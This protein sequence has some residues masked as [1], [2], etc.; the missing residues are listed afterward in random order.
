MIKPDVVIWLGPQPGTR[1]YRLSQD[2]GWKKLLGM[3]PE[4]YGDIV[5]GDPYGRSVG[6]YT[7]ER[8]YA[9]Q[10]PEWEDYHDDFC[11]ELARF[12]L[13]HP[14][15]DVA[16]YVGGLHNLLF[17][18]KLRDKGMLRDTLRRC[19]DGFGFGGQNPC[20]DRYIVDG[21]GD[22]R[23][24]TIATTVIEMMRM[25][26]SVHCEGRA[27][28]GSLFSKWEDVPQYT[29]Q[30]HEA[31]DPSA[32]S[33][34]FCGTLY[35]N[36]FI[37]SPIILEATKTRWLSCGY[38]IVVPIGSFNPDGTLPSWADFITQGTPTPTGDPTTP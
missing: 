27:S 5:I 36:I 1:G 13:G 21:A 26:T 19:L 4:S 11:N 18:E 16:A 15:K 22:I 14:A 8:C 3:P 29:K 20:F 2:S 31:V 6:P 10:H 30:S 24:D 37:E 17:W 28:P 35:H 38:N 32:L 23:T 7:L 25:V 33:P 34:V 9:Q 12:R